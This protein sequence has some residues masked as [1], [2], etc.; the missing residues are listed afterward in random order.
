MGPI[1]TSKNLR[2]PQKYIF[3]IDMAQLSVG[4]FL[5]KYPE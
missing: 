5:N 2:I 3:Y 1:K 4:E